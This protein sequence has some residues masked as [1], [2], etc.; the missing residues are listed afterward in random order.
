MRVPK[1]VCEVVY[2]FDF[3]SSVDGDVPWNTRSITQK[4]RPSSITLEK[5]NLGTH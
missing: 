1:F 4:A 2:V 5:G 3:A